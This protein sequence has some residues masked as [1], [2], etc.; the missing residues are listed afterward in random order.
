MWQRVKLVYY[1]ISVRGTRLTQVRKSGSHVYRIL[2]FKT[3]AARLDEIR[4]G[5]I[6]F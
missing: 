2:F 6:I 5:Y 1:D 3:S 4:A